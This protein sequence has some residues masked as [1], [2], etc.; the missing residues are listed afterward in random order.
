MAENRNCAA[1]VRFT[2]NETP[3]PLLLLLQQAAEAFSSRRKWASKS[4]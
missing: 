4:T 3:P 2:D 1:T